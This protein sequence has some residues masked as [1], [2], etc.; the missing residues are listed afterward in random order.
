[1]PAWQLQAAKAN[2]S[3]LVK[4]AQHEGPQEITVHG[5]PVAVVLS[6]TAFAELSGSNESLA[7][8]MQRS[9][10][11]GLENLDLRR[12]QSTTRSTEALF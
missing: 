12:D 7:S 4:L 5:K 9:P 1:M 2:L 3:E 10:L 6:Q 11:F 8:F